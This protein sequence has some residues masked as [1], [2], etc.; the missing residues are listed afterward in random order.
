MKTLIV[1]VL[2]ALLGCAEK[3]VGFHHGALTCGTCGRVVY[4]GKME[5]YANGFTWPAG[6]IDHHKPWDP[7]CVNQTIDPNNDRAFG[8]G[9]GAGY[10]DFC[11]G[12][13]HPVFPATHAKRYVDGYETGWRQAQADSVP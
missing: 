12:R 6:K 1:V 4:E 5:D 8:I 3:P 13:S 7:K 9:K 11:N 2:L 10:N